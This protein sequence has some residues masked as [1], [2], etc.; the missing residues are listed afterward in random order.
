MSRENSQTITE[1]T[2]LYVLIFLIGW[3]YEF[4]KSGYPEF[5]LFTYNAACVFI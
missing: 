5:C 1:K 4:L 2:Y 3:L